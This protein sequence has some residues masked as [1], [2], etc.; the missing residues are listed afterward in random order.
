M[1]TI[2]TALIWFALVSAAIMAGIYFTFSVFAMRALASLGDE[3]GANAMRAINRVILQSAF[4]PLFLASSAASLALVVLGMLGHGAAPHQLVAGGLVYVLGMTGV[5][6]L[7]N[8]PLNNRLE[9]ADP[10]TAAGQALW[11][12]YAVRWTRL[13]HIRTLACVAALVLFVLALGAD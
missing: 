13:N 9:S 7:G 10:A 2:L 8:V 6:M 12:D 4:L 3:D 11:R 1:P 5:T